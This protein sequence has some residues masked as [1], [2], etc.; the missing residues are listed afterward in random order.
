MRVSENK[1]YALL[2]FGWF[3]LDFDSKITLSTFTC[4][5]CLQ[6]TIEMLVNNWLNLTY[7][8]SSLLDLG[9]AR[10]VWIS[11]HAS[12]IALVKS[13]GSAFAIGWQ[14]SL[15]HHFAVSRHLL[16]LVC[17]HYVLLTALVHLVTVISRQLIRVYHRQHFR[18]ALAHSR[19]TLRRISKW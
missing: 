6:Q 17:V 18:E 15:H 8:W 12:F 9:T 14:S 3:A 7:K 2:S 11:H 16:I 13:R 10:S 19:N 4:P 1:E 5:S